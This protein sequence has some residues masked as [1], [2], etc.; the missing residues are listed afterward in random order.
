MDSLMEWVLNWW[1]LVTGMN[2]DKVFDEYNDEKD[3]AL[4]CGRSLVGTCLLSD[5]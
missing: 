5:F 4:S 3:L 2:S 1:C